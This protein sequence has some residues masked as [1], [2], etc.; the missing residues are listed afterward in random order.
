M[1][2]LSCIVLL[3]LG[4]CSDGASTAI[5]AAAG[6]G[7]AVDATDGDGGVAIDAALRLCERSGL[8]FCEDFEALPLGAA[9]NASSAAWD[10]ESA[11]GQ[12]AIDGVHARGQR[13]LKL[14]VD[15]N[16]RARL[17]VANLAPANNSLFG[18]M[19]AWVTAFPA[20]S[21]IV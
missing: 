4:A 5:D 20:S 10:T 6:D 9:N 14:S 8:M 16:G 13:A 7:A 21:T 12:L 2:K 11:G 15:G 18:V 17:T 3:L 19:H 1:G